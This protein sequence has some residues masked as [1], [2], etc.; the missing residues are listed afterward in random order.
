MRAAAW[1]KQ[2][3]EAEKT[4]CEESTRTASGEQFDLFL[5]NYATV[6]E[7]LWEVKTKQK[8]AQSRFRTKVLCA[9]VLTR[10]FKKLIKKGENTP[11]YSCFWRCGISWGC[12][13]QE[14][15]GS[16]EGALSCANGR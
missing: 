5:A 6:Y 10:F 13:Q 14:S 12:A 9:R 3:A 1:Q 2:I 16:H 8:Y 11:P 15:F 4:F 7:E